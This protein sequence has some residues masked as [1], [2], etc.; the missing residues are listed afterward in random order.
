V[1]TIESSD[2]HFIHSFSIVLGILIVFTILL[3]AFA[4]ALG[5]DQNAEQLE[6]PLVM[7]A[8]QQNTMPLG[9]EA[10]A[11]QDNK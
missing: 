9:H 4:R 10:I 7:K 1:S 3:F 5:K 8:A 6:D 11:G 2:T